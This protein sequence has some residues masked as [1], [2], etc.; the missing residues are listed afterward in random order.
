MSVP[1]IERVGR[2][3][4]ASPAPFARAELES[5][6][7]VLVRPN[8]TLPIVAVD[9][10]IGIGA[11]HET[12]EHA[13]ISHFLEHMFFKGTERYPLGAMDRIVKEMG[14]YNNAATSMEFT[15]YYI[16]A[17]AE[18]F[19]TALDLL[20]DHL[21][22]PALPE[23]EIERE[24][25]VVKEEIRRKNDSPHGRL[26]SALTT[27]AFGETAYAREVLGT[28]ASLDRI[29]PT[30]L[31]E[32]WRANYRADRL[33]VAV[34]GDVEPASAVDAVQARLG[35]LGRANGAPPVP[36]PPPVGPAAVEERMDVGQG[37]LAWGFQTAG[38]DELA[39]LCAI[40]VAATI[41]GEG[42]TSRLHRRLI[43]ELR[44]VTAV[45]A[46]TYGLQRA[47]LLGISAVFE[48]ERRETVEAEVASVM[49]AAAQQGLTGDEVRRAQ[50]I[51]A[52]DFAYDNETNAAM[53]GT[54]GEFELLFGYAGAYRQILAGIAA[55]T[56][57]A[58]TE[59]LA[60]RADP[61]RAVRAWV[62]PDGA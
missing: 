46:W 40:E 51:L 7:R 44:L 23:P 24:R 29:T 16:V 12:D 43:D 28:P 18:H 3:G 2:A 56:P 30:V 17:P 26:Y 57:E 48:P 25:Q 21:V 61:A 27:A 50:A 62:G 52:A 22:E 8:P 9:C 39:E 60:R 34:A 59:A 36:E 11:L 35:G 5:G 37:Y 1:R 6:L 38:R 14:G 20:A 47:G 32:Y 33:V 13:G 4:E 42:E 53:T 41:L 45:N 15:H 19:A 58:A 49:G 10:W 55:V 54:L 31:R